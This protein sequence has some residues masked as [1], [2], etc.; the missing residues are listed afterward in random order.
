MDAA[1]AIAGFDGMLEVEHLVVH[2]V[3]DGVAGRV[4]PVEYTADHD[5]IVGRVVVTEEA[6]RGVLAPGKERT[7]EEA[8]EEAEVEGLE[9]FFQV[10]VRALVRGDALASASL[11]NAFGMSDHGFAAGIATV[12]AGMVGVDGFAVEFGD[13]DVRDGAQ[14]GFGRA[15]EEVREADAELAFAQANGGV[16]TGEAIEADVD[17]RDGSARTEGAVFFL[18][19]VDEFSV[20]YKLKLAQW[21]GMG[22][23]RGMA[24]RG[25][26]RDAGLAGRGAQLGRRFRY[27]GAEHS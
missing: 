18:E 1:A 27:R 2:E 22:I 11:A 19:P 9:D 17:R 13:E 12:A 15:F 7:A 6:A 5:G 24:E 14:D 21:E 4:G 8:V 16:E 26:R 3:F 25:W 10:V 23:H 20:H